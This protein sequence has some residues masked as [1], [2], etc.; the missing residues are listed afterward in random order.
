VIL[1]LIDKG[2]I[3]PS[4]KRVFMDDDLQEPHGGTDNTDDNG[5][6]LPFREK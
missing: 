4:E 2:P 1:F 3:F 6:R 5:D